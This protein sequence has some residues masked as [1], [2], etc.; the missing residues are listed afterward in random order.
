M[1]DNNN[2]DG[3]TETNLREVADGHLIVRQVPRE[4]TKPA[5]RLPG[6][7]EP[8]VGSLQQSQ[9]PR[10]WRA[11]FKAALET[12]TFASDNS[13]LMMIDS[14]AR[15]DIRPGAIKMDKFEELRTIKKI[16]RGEQFMKTQVLD[17]L[18]LQRLPNGRG[19]VQLQPGPCCRHLRTGMRCSESIV[20]LGCLVF[21]IIL[22]ALMLL[23][24]VLLRHYRQRE[25]PAEGTAVSAA[26][27]DQL[28]KY[29]LDRSLVRAQ[30]ENG[31]LG[32]FGHFCYVVRQRVNLAGGS[33]AKCPRGLLRYQGSCKSGL[34]PGT[35]RN[36]GR[37]AGLASARH[38]QQN[39]TVL[40]QVAKRR[41]NKQESVVQLL[42]EAVSLTSVQHENVIPTRLGVCTETSPEALT[43]YALDIACGV[44]Y[45]HSRDFVHRDL[46]LRNCLINEYF[47]VKL[48]QW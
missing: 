7:E 5:P 16:S 6:H 46:A 37:G 40:L 30:Q 11:R 27:R 18:R 25:Y 41:K 24:F 15:I 48:R 22:L 26:V 42:K 33:A 31:A 19:A 2:T 12:T 39:A 45:L 47:Q 14:K 21:F 8:A 17:A 38:L 10:A 9:Q 23:F 44:E 36:S 4:L 13:L 1:Q 29:E 35:P 34:T 3:C 43:R 20:A 28:V 32:I